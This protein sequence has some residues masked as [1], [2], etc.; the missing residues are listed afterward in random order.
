MNEQ[1]DEV[2]EVELTSATE[3]F[4]IQGKYEYL[5]TALDMYIKAL[6]EMTMV[7]ENA[8]IAM[9]NN[10]IGIQKNKYLKE[11][12][13]MMYEDRDR[14]R[15]LIV[16][17]NQTTGVLVVALN[18]NGLVVE[19]TYFDILGRQVKPTDGNPAHQLVKTVV[20]QVC[21]VL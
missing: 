9:V 4:L 7:E 6:E 15:S 21:E 16:K 5:A 12:L 17:S 3:Q 2:K 14:I 1:L 13:T 10:A 20:D 18:D 19:D 11:I 8:A